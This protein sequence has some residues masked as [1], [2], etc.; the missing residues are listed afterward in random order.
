MEGEG[1]LRY[2]AFDA[3]ELDLDGRRLRVGGRDVALEP[4]AFDVLSL[5]VQAPGKAFSRDDILDAVWGHRHVTPGVLNRVVTLVRHALGENAGSTRYI[6]TLHG[7]GY[8]FDGV[9]RCFAQRAE[10]PEGLAAAASIASATP[11]S[12][13][14]EPDD[15]S[16]VLP[17]AAGAEEQARDA[18]TAAASDVSAKP[19]HWSASSGLWLLAASLVVVAI[20]ILLWRRTSP[21]KPAAAPPPTLVVL[22]LRA[23]GNDKNEAIF[24]D[25]LSEELTTELA[26]VDGLRLIASVSAARARELGFDAA[27][28]AERLHVNYAIEG[29]L[30]ESGDALRIDLRLIE[31][32]SGRTVWAQSYDRQTKDVFGVQQ[33]IAQAV[34]SAL[35]LHLPLDRVA[36]K[37]PDLAV[38][39]EYLRLRHIFMTRPDDADYDKAEVALNALA[40]RAPDYAPVHGLLALNL[41][42]H[43][44]PGRELEALPE[45][46]RAL[47]LDPDNVYAHA[48]LGEL[49]CQRDE[50]ND[51]M[52]ELR[53]TLARNPTDPVM[54]NLVGMRLAGLGYGEEALRLAQVGYAIDPLSYW[55]VANLGAQLDALGRHTE[56]QRYLDALPGLAGKPNVV[57][58]ELRWRNAVWRKDLADARDIAAN[59]PDD[60]ARKPLYVAFSAALADPA[61]WPQALAKL[62]AAQQA[63]DTPLLLQLQV[64]QPDETM[65][66]RFFEKPWFFYGRLLWVPEYAAIRQGPAF[67]DFL[68]RT[69][70]LAYWNAN[71]WPPQ[72]KPDGDGARCD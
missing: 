3:V 63:S 70:M 14:S 21:A 53:A 23:I 32:P 22:P 72:C 28:L 45:A 42:T 33:E 49:A 52:K 47:R 29:S 48:V 50:W 24:A 68:R 10:P 27:Q 5:L 25:G 38:F 34:A 11:S 58:D 61:R 64:P 59:M 43:L 39:R 8:R 66:L 36:V 54:N 16:V 13:A 57:T 30:R 62:R 41:A 67:S 7:V 15:P 2:I 31:T 71:G 12:S 4:K 55:A 56:A 37:P 20:G 19:R 44:E 9:V 51:C 69:K 35:A 17:D 40:A 18:P 46:T 65:A 26:R 1:R 6:H 60:F